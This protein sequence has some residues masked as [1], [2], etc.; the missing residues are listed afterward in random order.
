LVSQGQTLDGTYHLH[1]LV[2]EGGMGVVFEATHARLAGR[3]AIKVLLPELAARP[4]IRAR[5]DR[6]AQITSSLQHPNIVQ[7]I[8]HNSTADG[9]SYLVMEFLSGESLAARLARDGRL[10]APRV[11]DIVEQIAAGLAAAHARGIV[12][13]DLKPDNIYLVP[14][15]GRATELIK[16]LDFGI[17]KVNWGRDAISREI[18]GTPQYMAPEQ[19]EGRASDVDAT[20]D[21]FALAIIAHELLTGKN[22]FASES[23]GETFALVR[24]GVLPP[25][26]LGA[27][28]DRV[29]ARAL[30]QETVQR[31]PSVAAFAEA[32]RAAVLPPPAQLTPLPVALADAGSV[33]ARRVPTRRA[34]RRGRDVR[35]GVAAAAAIAITSFLGTGAANRVS[36]R[37]PAAHGAPT[38]AVADAEAIAAREGARST[39]LVA[40]P[41][42]AATVAPASLASFEVRP[43]TRRARSAPRVVH[44]DR[45]L[46]TIPTA[47]ARSNPRPALPPDEDATLPPSSF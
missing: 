8:D 14:V 20:T 31:F 11:V 30:S 5:F 46:L 13:R 44:D 25:A 1:R 18:C 36:A 26:G 21:Q 12:H 47:P 35:L 3:Y 45:P 7:V 9:T 16:I 23:I 22:A 33:P 42:A 41:P 19:V 15:E 28:V 38:A 2:G 17:S 4:E 24:S 37:K 43:P 39:E 6:E 40:A 34:R 10:A 32:F 29:L 27:A